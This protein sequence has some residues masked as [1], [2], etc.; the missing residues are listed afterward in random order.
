MGYD[1]LSIGLRGERVTAILTNDPA[2]RTVQAVR[3]G[4]PLSAA[5]ASY[6]KAA[7]CNP[8]SPDKQAKHPFCV[9]TVPVGRMTVDGD[10]IKAI[11]LSS[12]S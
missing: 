10:P 11:E 4:D 2:A 3:I 9:I 12:T 8:N 1:H 7:K 6:R 5:R